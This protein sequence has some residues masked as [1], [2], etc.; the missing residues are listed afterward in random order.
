MW[1]TSTSYGVDKSNQLENVRAD[2]YL[3]VK[4]VYY[5]SNYH[6]TS[7]V[8]TRIS[9]PWKKEWHLHSSVN[10]IIGEL[11]VNIY[12]IALLMDQKKGFMNDTELFTQIE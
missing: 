4:R 2:V 8:M 9:I 11:Y 1:S 3:M 5:Y 6:S 12:V 7:L 10:H